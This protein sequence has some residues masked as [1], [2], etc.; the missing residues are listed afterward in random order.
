MTI[1]INITI[2]KKDEFDFQHFLVLF[3]QS[4]PF[5]DDRYRLARPS[6]E[7]HDAQLG[8]TWYKLKLYF[9]AIYLIVDFRTITQN[10]RYSWGFF[11]HNEYT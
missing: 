2:N 4:Y 6:E 5:Y 11:L 3:E 9:S 8:N 10:Y 7:R 1:N